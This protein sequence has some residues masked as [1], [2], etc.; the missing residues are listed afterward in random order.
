M[1][2]PLLI[3]LGVVLGGWSF[4]SLLGNERQRLVQHRDAAAKRAAAGAAA[5]QPETPVGR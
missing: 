5:T 4:L 3:A 2:L 1:T